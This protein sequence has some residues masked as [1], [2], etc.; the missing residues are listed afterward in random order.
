[1]DIQKLKE[2]I[3]RREKFLEENPKMREFQKKIEEELD[4]AGESMH[5]RLAVMEAMLISSAQE[6]IK[7]MKELS[8]IADITPKG[9]RQ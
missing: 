4:K 6:L 7:E 9:D 1:M 8:L 5:N 2:A 3:E